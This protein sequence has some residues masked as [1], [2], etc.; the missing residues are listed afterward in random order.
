MR[1]RL[2]PTRRGG[3]GAAH[4]RPGIPP[5]RT[6]PLAHAHGV[7]RETNRTKQLGPTSLGQGER[8]ADGA[9]G[10]C[11]SLRRRKVEKKKRHCVAP[12]RGACPWT[13]VFVCF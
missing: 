13:R 4:V 2:R 12:P 7:G 8:G 3:G 10:T 11:A 6:R 5:K 9:L 1:C